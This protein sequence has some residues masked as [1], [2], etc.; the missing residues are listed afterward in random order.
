MLATAQARR[1]RKGEPPARGG[2]ALPIRLAI[3]SRQRLI[4][5]ALAAVLGREEGIQILGRAGP[6][7]DEIHANEREAD[8]VL[9]DI[10]RR[11]EAMAPTSWPPHDGGAPT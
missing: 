5:D 7:S 11:Q 8:V 10:P 2:P 1:I 4:R 9:V 3:V 6:G